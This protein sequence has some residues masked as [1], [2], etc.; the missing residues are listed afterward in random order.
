MKEAV[1][2][3]ITYRA[4]A[5]TLH[6]TTNDVVMREAVTVAGPSVF[7]FMV[8]PLCLSRPRDSLRR[9]WLVKRAGP[10]IR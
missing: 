3:T 5:T 7:G 2:K 8:G 9:L 4:T 1:A 10:S 6:F